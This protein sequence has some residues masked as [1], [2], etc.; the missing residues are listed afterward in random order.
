MSAVRRFLPLVLLV[1]PSVLVLGVLALYPILRVLVDSFFNV[2][3]ASGQRAFTGLANYRAVLADSE[4]SASFFNT[5]QFTVVASV[6]EVVLGGAL[7]LL[8]FRAFRG[9]RF[10]I[11]LLILPMML[12]TLVCSAIWRNWLNYSGFLNALLAV[13]GLPGVQWLS[14]P[15]LAI[16]S[17]ILV[18]VWQWTPMA[19]LIILAGL[20][21][22]APELY[23]A[24]RTDGASEWQCLR[25]ITLPLIVPQIVLAM[26]LRSIDTF[27]LF[28]KVYALTGGGPGNATQ[29]LSTY[30]YDTGFRF[31]NMGPASAASV[32]M[33]LVS[34]VLVSANV[35][36]S[37]R[38]AGTR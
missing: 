28:D 34:A 27:K 38:K 31:F 1:G 2:D 23:E 6:S 15:N 24:A 36:L 11:P 21:S 4:F 35:W 37:I 14:D 16:W 17:L 26:L 19:F 33:L 32:M 30:I 7:A 25:H 12:S 9:R 8:F 18:D 10:V 29:T 3:Y 13:F 5:L 22:I 20:Q